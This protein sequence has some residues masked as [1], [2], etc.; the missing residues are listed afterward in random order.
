M[1]KVS[2]LPV[3]VF[4]G[5]A[6]LMGSVRAQTFPL[7][8]P[9]RPTSFPLPLPSRPSVGGYAVSSGG[10]Q[11]NLGDEQ[12]KIASV[13][14]GIVSTDGK[15]YWT[16]G[17]VITSLGSNLAS[18]SSPVTGL[19]Q[20]G[21]VVVTGN[22]SFLTAPTG[23]YTSFLLAQYVPAGAKQNIAAVEDSELGKWLALK[24]T[25]EVISWEIP[26]RYEFVGGFSN[27]PVPTFPVPP[28]AQS[29]VVAISMSGEHCLALKATGQVVA[30]G[31]VAVQ[32]VPDQY[33]NIV[34]VHADAASILPPNLNGSVVSIAAIP[35]GGIALKDDGSVVQW[36]KAGR[37][38]SPVVDLPPVPT[39]VTSR[40]IVAV[41]AH[42]YSDELAAL[43]SS[44]DAYQWGASGGLYKLEGKSLVQATSGDY[45]VL[46]LSISPGDVFAKVTGFPLEKLAELVAQKIIAQNPSNYGLAT[47]SDLSTAVSNAIAQVQANPNNFGLYSAAQ[48]NA[49]FQSGVAAGSAKPKATAKSKARRGAKRR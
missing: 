14:G 4:L 23:G 11:V 16:S 47:K 33:N 25:G 29:G 21:E 36:G 38:D 39:E 45:G 9:V 2:N 32:S 22:A 7:P 15:A 46:G 10:F 40:T 35:N 24:R 31:R 5:L 27:T 1:K 26:G 18:V 20:S 43:S 42:G 41:A 37:V 19:T 34:P 6:V 48:F 8:I 13:R 3:F 30:W 12:G 28:A 44:G 17:S 49:N